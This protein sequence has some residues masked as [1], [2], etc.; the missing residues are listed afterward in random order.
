MAN[1]QNL[2][3]LTAEAP[4]SPLGEAQAKLFGALHAPSLR[5]AFEDGLVF[6]SST[7]RARQTAILALEQADVPEPLEQRVLLQ[8]SLKEIYRGDWDGKVYEGNLEQQWLEMEAADPSGWRAPGAGSES[9][10]DVQSRVAK[11][12]AETTMYLRE[13]ALDGEEVTSYV[14][15]HHVV[16][17]C[18]LCHVLGVGLQHHFGIENTSAS[19]LQHPGSQD[20]TWSVKVVNDTRHLQVDPM[21]QVSNKK[22]RTA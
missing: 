9:R 11:F 18:L 17:E 8:D 21:T 13:M 6:S 3:G 7:K 19:V 5:K 2:V 16:I 10:E 14:F 22:Q 20:G 4:L 15:C 1:L 12:L